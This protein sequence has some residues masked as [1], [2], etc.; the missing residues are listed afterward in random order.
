MRT[1]DSQTGR[2][3]EDAEVKS[4]YFLFIEMSGCFVDKGKA[5]NVSNP[6]SGRSRIS[7]MPIPLCG[8]HRPDVAADLPLQLRQAQLHCRFSLLRFCLRSC[9]KEGFC[10]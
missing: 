1:W 10:A 5:A 6:A 7:E 9:W 2:G 3:G 4:K 8:E